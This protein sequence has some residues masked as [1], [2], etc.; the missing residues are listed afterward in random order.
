MAEDMDLYPLRQGDT[1]SG[2]WVEWRVRA[3]CK[4]DWMV[5]MSTKPEVGFF[6]MR[7][8]AEAYQQDPAG[9]LPDDDAAL[10][11]LAG[12]GLA[13]GRWR[14]LRE[15]GALRGWAPCLVMAAG[16]GGQ[17][18]RRLAHP[19]V[20]EVALKSWG[21]QRASRE[22]AAEG[23]RRKQMSRVRVHLR[24]AGLKS[25][26]IRSDRYVAMVLERLSGA[27]KRITLENVEAE[28]AA[29]SRDN[30]HFHDFT[31]G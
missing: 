23:A 13:V 18:R 26:L 1:L 31:G 10:A 14:R 15:A 30:V 17:D 5:E 21:F 9:T 8:M 16:E 7:L 28:L 3:L 12:L 20:T 2:D 6:A 19:V 24:T 27:G 25:D 29:M 4:S 22:G 11:Q